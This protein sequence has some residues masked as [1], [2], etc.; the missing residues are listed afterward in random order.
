MNGVEELA[1]L[2]PRDQAPRDEVLAGGRV[3]RQ[4]TSIEDLKNFLRMPVG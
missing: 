3:R 4:I 2:S 1:A